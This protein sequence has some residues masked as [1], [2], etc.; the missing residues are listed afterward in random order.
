MMAAA[1]DEQLVEKIVGEVMTRIRPISQPVR[2]DSGHQLS[3]NNAQTLR[4]AP[5]GPHPQALLAITDPVV[6][7]DL[8]SQRLAGQ[9]F[10][11][12]AICPKS[13]ITPSAFDF[14]QTKKIFWHRNTAEAAPKADKPMTRWKAFV[15]TAT[16]SVLQAIE[17]TERQT[18]GKRWSHEL[19]GTADEA[20]TAA[21]SAINRG[22]THGVAVFADHAELIACRANRSERVNAA[23]VSDAQVLPALKQYMQLN[24]M[25]VRPSGRS[26]FELRNLL[27]E[28]G[29]S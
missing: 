9:S 26:F 10:S 12:V 4:S 28:F 11:A 25:V 27:K 2:A 3:S 7:A 22:E 1:L 13:I 18:F 19:L 14:L 16:S 5:L 17:H 8:L 23:V 15:V 21:T 24:L 29:K 20:V 6:T